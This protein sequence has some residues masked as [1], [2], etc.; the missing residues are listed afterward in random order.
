MEG[1]HEMSI[2]T[3][4]RTLSTEQLAQFNHLLFLLLNAQ[5]TRK[6]NVIYRGERKENLNYKMGVT[7]FSALLEMLF[8][9]GDK[10]KS[11]WVTANKKLHKER[12]IFR[13]ANDSTDTFQAIF[14]KYKSVFRSKK[15]A[16]VH[17]IKNNASFV[18]FINDKN[19]TDRFLKKL[20][21][22]PYEV[23][24]QIRDL[25]LIP[26]HHVGGVGLGSKS[27][28]ISTTTSKRVAQTFSNPSEGVT[29]VGW[30]PKMPYPFFSQSGERELLTR[31]EIPVIQRAFYAGQ[32]ELSL[33]GGL[34]PHY[35]IG[36]IDHQNKA[37][38]I[39]PHLFLQ[40]QISFSSVMNGLDIDQKDF[41]KVIRKT[42]LF[43]FFTTNGFDFEDE[44]FE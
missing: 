5:A 31:F 39:N 40:K 17:F 29:L 25:L 22:E 13:L 37:F 34:L 30:Q 19:S 36:V 27:F 15:S 1:L 23:R 42:N 9:L 11:Y 44:I 20:E 24:I 43:G 38:H 18:D 32:K 16:I 6:V 28:F 10:G 14:E 21:Q 41:K 8:F 33:K 3:N 2:L 7:H 35:M 12:K 26:L 4:G